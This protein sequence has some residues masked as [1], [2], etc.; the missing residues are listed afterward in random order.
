MFQKFSII[1]LTSTGGL[2]AIMCIYNINKSTPQSKSLKIYLVIATLISIA[3]VICVCGQSISDESMKLRDILYES[4][5]YNWNIKNR[6]IL[7]LIITNIMQP[8]EISFYNLIP[9]NLQ[10]LTKGSKFAYS[11]AAV[12]SKMK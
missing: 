12:L 9:A 1:L 4:P 11:I 6:K 3:V 2:A 5:W 8:W 7:L 10:F